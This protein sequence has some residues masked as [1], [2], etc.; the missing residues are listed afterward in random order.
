[1]LPLAHPVHL[2]SHL[3]LHPEVEVVH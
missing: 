1:M 3:L 2:R